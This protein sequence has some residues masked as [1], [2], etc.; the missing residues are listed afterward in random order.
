MPV[1]T[2]ARRRTLSAALSRAPSPLRR[3]DTLRDDTSVGKDRCFAQDGGMPPAD[4]LTHRL[5]KPHPKA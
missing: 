3:I 4:G 2:L 1:L 5:S